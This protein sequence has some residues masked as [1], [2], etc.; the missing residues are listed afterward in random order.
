MTLSPSLTPSLKPSVSELTFS[1]R[2]RLETAAPWPSAIPRK[3][4]FNDSASKYLGQNPRL[5]L[6]PLWV[7]FAPP[8]MRPDSFNPRVGEILFLYLFLK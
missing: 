4:E 6:N 7:R 8:P 2:R 3:I 1:V 5:F